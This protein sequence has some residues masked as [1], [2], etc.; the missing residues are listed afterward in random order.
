MPRWPNLIN[1]PISSFTLS[2][3][4]S[5]PW[6]YL[7][8]YWNLISPR[9]GYESRD[10]RGRV[11]VTL[12]PSH[13]YAY[14]A[15]WAYRYRLLVQYELGRK[16]LDNE[17]VNHIDGRIDNDRLDNLEVM[18]AEY[19]GRYHA[20]LIDVAGYRDNSGRFIEHDVNDV[21]IHNVNRYAAVISPRDIKYGEPVSSTSIE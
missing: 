2:G 20:A 1:Q 15:G 21:S 16:L 9:Y 11:R 18:G 3:C 12:H 6:L 17:H 10:H 5:R 8:R 13:P 14:R 19:H 4:D 7:R